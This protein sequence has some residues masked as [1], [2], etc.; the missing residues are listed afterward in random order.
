M[1][2]AMQRAA[3]D[4]EGAYAEVLA[5]AVEARMTSSEFRDDVLIPA[6]CALDHGSFRESHTLEVR[7]LA[8]LRLS[9]LIR[10]RSAGSLE[11]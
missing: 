7:A 11:A 1:I 10:R 5:D 6:A 3:L 9:A 4:E 8:M 2:R